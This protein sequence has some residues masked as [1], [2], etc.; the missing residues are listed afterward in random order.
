MT[1][2]ALKGFST[3]GRLFGY[4]TEPGLDGIVWKVDDAEA[5]IVRRI[6]SM[7]LDGLSMKAIAIRL[8]NEGVAFPAK[9]THRGPD[10]GGW[11]V[12]TI[13]TILLNRKYVGDW[14][15]NKTMFVKDPESGKRNAVARPKTEWLSERRPDLAIIADD[16]WNRVEDRLQ[17][18]RAAYGGTKSSSR[19]QGRA[20]E[21]H[22]PHLLS[23][24][25][26]CGHCGARIRSKAV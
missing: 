21:L 11:A 22:S 2:R 13:H 15:W 17:T 7:Y 23:G 20:P 1:G 9:A 8:N 19:P 4:R 24:L 16:L 14:V 5:S 18:F 3:G 26:R 12:S 25:M 6:F 10:R